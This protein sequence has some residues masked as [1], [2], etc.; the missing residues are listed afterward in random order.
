MHLAGS[1]CHRRDNYCPP[2]QTTLS[3]PALQGDSLRLDEPLAAPGVFL[4][5]GTHAELFRGRNF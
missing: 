5:A 1:D 2:F 4:V 3:E